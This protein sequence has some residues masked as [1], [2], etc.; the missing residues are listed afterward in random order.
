MAGGGACVA[1]GACMAGGCVWPGA[2]MARGCMARAEHV[3]LGGACVAGGWCV[4]G[5][6]HGWGACV[7]GGH[8]W[9][10]ACMGMA[11]VAC[12]PSPRQILLLRHTVNHRAVRILLECILVLS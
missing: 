9:L 4:A 1:R 12:T 6:V 2:C 7:A 11:C 8:A 3:W 5:G 10:G